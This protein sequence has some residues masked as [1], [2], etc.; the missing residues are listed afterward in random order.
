MQINTNEINCKYCDDYKTT[1]GTLTCADHFQ[2]SHC[3]AVFLI[4]YSYNNGY[5]I[6]NTQPMQR[7]FEVTK[8][9]LPKI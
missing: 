2:H 5:C 7:L 1:E 9:E 4:T 6:S 8:N 3:E